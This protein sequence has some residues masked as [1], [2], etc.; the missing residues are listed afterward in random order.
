M[1]RLGR[2]P[3]DHRV[4][5]QLARDWPTG[6]RGRWSPRRSRFH[7]QRARTRSALRHPF[8]PGRFVSAACPLSRRLASRSPRQLRRRPRE[9]HA[10]RA[11]CYRQRA[12]K[13]RTLRRGRLLLARRHDHADQQPRIAH[14]LDVATL[15]GPGE[16][17]READGRVCVGIIETV[18]HGGGTPRRKPGGEPRDLRTTG[19]ARRV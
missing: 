14:Q 1:K 17:T 19:R 10:W 5:V 8:G 2:K 3:A 13:T 7:L 9:S 16:Q 12:L 4:P 11:L 15:C 6:A 18:G